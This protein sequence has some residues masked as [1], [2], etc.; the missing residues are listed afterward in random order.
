MEKS[1]LQSEILFY[2]RKSVFSRKDR[3]VRNVPVL[4]PKTRLFSGKG[5]FT[6]EI[7]FYCRK[8]GFSS[9]KDRFVRKTQ[10]L[11]SKTNFSF[12]KECF[13]SEIVF[14]CGNLSF[15]REKL[16]GNSL[17]TS[18]KD[19]FLRKIQVLT[20]KTRFS[21]RKEYFTSE[22]VFYSGNL[23]FSREKLVGNPVFTSGKERF[24][25]NIQVSTPKRGFLVQRSSLLLK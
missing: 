25:R 2:C 4:T 13:T 11:T 21:P 19:R 10:V 9:R 24:V 7:V 17:F 22:I 23:S 14:S 5:Y 3:F 6:S 18:G 12:G 15:S 16:V 8:S 1:T 20:A